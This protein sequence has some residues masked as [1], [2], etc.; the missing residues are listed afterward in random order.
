[1]LPRSH[2]RLILALLTASTAGACASSANGPAL[3]VTRVVLYQSGIGYVEQQGTVSGESVSIQVRPEQI[4]DVLAT[5]VVLD[6]EGRSAS[7]SLPVDQSAIPTAQMPTPDAGGMLQLLQTFRGADVTVVAA[8]RRVRGRIVGAERRADGNQIVSI[9]TSADEIVAIGVDEIDSVQLRNE[10]LALGLERSLDRSLSDADWK[11]VDVTL[12]F[13]DSQRRNIQL[14]YVVEMPAWRPVYRAIVLGD[15]ELLLQGW[16]IV[17]NV[18]GADWNRVNMSLTAG[19]PISFRYDLH[20]P[21]FVTRPDLSGYGATSAADLRPPTPVAARPQLEQAQRPAAAPA[22]APAQEMMARSRADSFGA[23]SD[24]IGAGYGGAQSPRPT[25]D[26]STM[27]NNGPASA[28]GTTVGGLFRFDLPD[29]VTVPDQSATMVPLI[30]EVIS[31]DDVLLF[32][33]MSGGNGTHPYRALVLDNRT[34]YPIQAAPMTIYND[35]QFVGEGITPVIEVG[36]EAF[37]PYALDTSVEISMSRASESGEVRLMAISD[38]LVRV[39]SASVEI[40]NISVTGNAESPDRLLVQVPKMN[41]YELLNPPADIQE[42]PAYY[43]IPINIDQTTTTTA[44]F[45]QIRRQPTQMQVFTPQ[46]RPIIAAFIAGH[47]GDSAA[48]QLQ[49]L[50]GMLEELGSLSTE[51]DGLRRQRADVQNRSAELRN[52]IATL[53]TTTSSQELRATLVDRLAEQDEI[54]GSI[55]TQLVEISEREAA[56]RVQISEFMTGLELTFN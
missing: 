34:G 21:R 53:G 22:P 47:P 11:P 41:G 27:A 8:N 13:P 44:S 9:Y 6:S 50:Q 31:G 25:M 33:P 18:S 26:M 20:S 36:E 28:S 19:T 17:D 42:H 39:E 49:E 52:N 48:R 10:G 7:V 45:R 5:L 1:M 56:L 30:N 38:G 4:N 37:I 46:L 16:G 12:H 55:A 2:A 35:G 23:L 54:L 51:A 32:Q 29:V 43:I 24:D 15:G 14:S 40:T 3:D